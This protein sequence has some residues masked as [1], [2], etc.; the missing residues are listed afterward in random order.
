MPSSLEFV[1]CEISSVDEQ[2]VRVAA[3]IRVNKDE[4]TLLI[5]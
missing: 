2:A 3:R 5:V 1:G 4:V